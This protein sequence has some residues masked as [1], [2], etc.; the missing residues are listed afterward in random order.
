MDIF[1]SIQIVQNPKIFVAEKCFNLCTLKIIV[2]TLF[3]PL[4]CGGF[5]FFILEWTLVLV[6][7]F[8]PYA[9]NN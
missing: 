7:S 3:P 9:C 6:L 1:P 2:Y 4:F 8:C 5:P